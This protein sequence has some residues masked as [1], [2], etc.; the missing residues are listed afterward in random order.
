MTASILPLPEEYWTDRGPFLAKLHADYGPVVQARLG[1][2]AVVFM[3]GPEANR[4][5]LQTDRQAFSHR[6]GWGWAFGRTSS[7]RN[8]LTMDGEEHRRNREILHP[9]F[10]VRHVE[11]YV[12]LMIR[13]IDRRLATW[14]ARSIIDVYE[15]TR[16]IALDVVAE[17]LL[18]LRPGPELSLCRAVYL[19]GAH[20][21]MD[22]FAVL[23]RDK[24]AERRTLPTGDALCLLARARDEWG[25]P[26]SNEQILAHADTLL[27]AG[28]E[29]TASLAAWALYVLAMHPDQA[30][31]VLEESLDPRQGGY[32]TAALNHGSA[33]A[34]V[35]SEA[36]R[37]YP[38][39]PT[40]PRGL[41]QDVTFQ[42]H[43]LP[44]GT[45]AVYSAAA[46]HLLPG[47]WSAPHVFDPDR[48]A[49][50][51][52]EH[53]R[54]PYA[55]VGFGGGART[56]IGRAMAR[57]ELALLLTRMLQ[58]F[59]LEVLLGQRIVQRYGVT[60]RPRHGIRMRVQARERRK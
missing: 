17:T 45:M 39:V 44:M 20:R 1:Q 35:L 18:G 31:R 53:K 56:C 27:V 36:E 59:R 5:I 2:A 52:D 25:S 41:L 32:L 51:R 47:V 19:H 28:H 40:A 55:L 22:D 42:G 16:V 12:P 58:R 29:T 37:L 10:A 34:R 8:L 6:L 30:R 15:E 33:L 26:L 21:R 3:L 38:P 57:V 24:A 14:V 43:R 11:S 49:S 46:T 23:L 60:S 7:P 50:P 4:C 9:A 13:V 54:V 48:F